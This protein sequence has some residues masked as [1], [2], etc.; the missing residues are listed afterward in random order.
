MSRYITQALSPAA[1]GMAAKP[2]CTHA[3]CPELARQGS[4]RL[5]MCS[6][7]EAL[8]LHT[9]LSHGAA[10]VSLSSQAGAQ[11]SRVTSH[12][13]TGQGEWSGEGSLPE[14]R[15]LVSCR[16]LTSARL[17]GL[18]SSVFWEVQEDPVPFRGEEEPWK[19]LV[20]D[21]MLGGV[22]RLGR[23]H[24]PYDAGAG[25]T[26]GRRSESHL[27]RVRVWARGVKV[28]QVPSRPWAV[29]LAMRSLPS[30]PCVVG[31]AGV[32]GHPCRQK[33]PSVM[34]ADDV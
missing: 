29:L 2:G 12:H 18:P 7:S 14:P 19:G 3:S 13:R 30:S 11:R 20:S 32:F 4:E 34:P 16:A 15:D 33:S 8:L 10:E 1:R 17:V 22:C 26:R 31:R 28:V 9:E 5:A 6:Q 23:G 25:Q 24:S 27:S 21:L